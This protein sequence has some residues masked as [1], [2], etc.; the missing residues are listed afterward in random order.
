MRI[1]GSRGGK[2]P[3]NPTTEILVLQGFPHLLE[4]IVG[5]RCRSNVTGASDA[6]MQT[7][8]Q[9]RASAA[10]TGQVVWAG[11]SSRLSSTFGPERNPVRGTLG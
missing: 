2:A 1:R 5:D 6:P 4:A 8:Q 7:R 9:M 11:R 10:C 3:G